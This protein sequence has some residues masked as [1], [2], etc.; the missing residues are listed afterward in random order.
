MIPMTHNGRD[1]FPSV[2]A[3]ACCP[4]GKMPPSI[5]YPCSLEPRDILDGVKIVVKRRQVAEPLSVH[6][7]DTAGIIEGERFGVRKEDRPCCEGV[8]GE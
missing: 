4:A 1:T 7:R 6:I 5:R 3:R 2:T 8:G